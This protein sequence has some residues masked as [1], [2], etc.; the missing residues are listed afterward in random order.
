MWR[1]RTSYGRKSGLTSGFSFSK[2]FSTVDSIVSRA[3]CLSLA[4]VKP[5]FNLYIDTPRLFRI[6][7]DGDGDFDPQ[8]GYLVLI[9]ETDQFVVQVVLDGQ[10]GR[11]LGELLD[12][13]D[14]LHLDY[15]VQLFDE[16][17]KGGRCAV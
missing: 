8:H 16:I 4:G 11:R 17:G 12:V 3:S 1:L 15:P 14:E 13:R 2:C 9:L 10:S 5:Y 6:D 7:V